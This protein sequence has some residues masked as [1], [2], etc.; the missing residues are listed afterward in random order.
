MKRFVLVLFALAA[1]GMFSACKKDKKKD[2][3]PA[4]P[5]AKTAD[6]GAADPAKPEDKPA[7]PAAATATP[8][9]ATDPAAVAVES[10]GVAECDAFVK[11][12]MECEKYPQ[13]S[14]DAVKE[15]V[16]AWKD[17][18]SKG[19]DAAKSVADGCK[20]AAETADAQLKAAGC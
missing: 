13:A 7:D 5:A 12:Q 14:K 6:P 19:A 17:Q 8:V 10:T 11:R 15:S 1:V 9:S 3:E 18:A 20:K 16:K 2:A 4:D